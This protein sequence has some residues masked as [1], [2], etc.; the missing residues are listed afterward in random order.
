MSRNEFRMSHEFPSGLKIDIESD[1]ILQYLTDRDEVST[2]EG[3][4]AFQEKWRYLAPEIVGDVDYEIFCRLCHDS[5]GRE[6]LV[7]ELWKEPNISVYMN[8]YFPDSFLNVARTIELFDVTTG[9]VFLRMFHEGVYEE[10]EDGT[11]VIPKTPCR[12]EQVIPPLV[13]QDKPT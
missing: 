3:L 4:K 5:E 10:Q 12:V 11:W 9:L 2:K 13:R 6:N 8:L 1:T 7:K